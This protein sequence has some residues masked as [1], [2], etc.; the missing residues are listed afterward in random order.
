MPQAVGLTD[1]LLKGWAPIIKD[2]ELLPS[3]KGRFEVTLDDDLIFSKAKQGRH[4]NPGEIAALVRDR[5][6]PEV[7]RT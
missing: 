4:A 6:G 5:I 3:S 1:E 2:I 7:R